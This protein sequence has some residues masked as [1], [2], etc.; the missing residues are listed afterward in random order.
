[1]KSIGYNFRK[2]FSPEGLDPLKKIVDKEKKID[3][4]YLNMKASPKNDFRMFMALKPFF[5]Q[6][7][8]EMF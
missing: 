3:C 4:K 1:M 5:S 2:N 8:M 7:F 6:S